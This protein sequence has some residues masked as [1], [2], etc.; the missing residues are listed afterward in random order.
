M[1]QKVLIANRGEIACRI[2][3]T[4]RSLGVR[5]VAV[6]SEADRHARHVRE[7]DEAYCI[8]PAPAALSY[9]NQKE[10][11]RIAREAGA[12]G[13]HPGYGFLSENA[14][15][16]EA[17][18]E[19][20]LAFCGPTGEQM[21][22]FGLKHTARSLAEASGTP[23]LPG[24]GLLK[25][26]TEAVTAAA[27]IGYPV[28]LKSSAGGGGIGMRR[29]ADEAALRESFEAVV[30]LGK[31]NFGEGGVFLEKLITRAR[32]IEV[33][34]FG[35]GKGQVWSLGER[36]CS[37]QRRNQKVVEETPAPGLTEEVREELHRTARDLAASIHYRSAGTVEFLYDV[38]EARF[39]FLEMNTRLQ[40]EHPVTEEVWGVDLVEAMVRLAAGES[41]KALFADREAC[42]AA[43]EVR[44]YAEDPARDFRPDCGL[45]TAWEVP[46]GIRC[47]G[48]IEAGTEVSPHY[49]PMLAKLIVWGETRAEALEKLQRGLGAVQL[50]GL[51]TN[52]AYLQE[53]AGQAF[54]AEG[55]MTTGSLGEMPF[56]P[57]QVE[58]LEAG[59]QTTV[60]DFPGRIGYWHVGVPPSGPMDSV[61]LRLGNRSLGNP[62][63]APALEATLQGPKLRFFEKTWV[64]L[65]G[66]RSD[67]FW[68]GQPVPFG[69]PFEVSAGSVLDVGSLSGRGQRMYVAIRGGF[70]LPK[71]LGSASTFILGQFGG[72]GGRVLQ[73]GDVLPWNPVSG[74]F[75]ASPDSLPAGPEFPEVWEIGVLSGPHGA[76][77]FFREEYLQEFLRADWEVHFNSARTGVRLIG[78]KPGWVREDG[79]E[80]GLHPSNIHDNAY[81]V[82]AIDFTGD[83]PVI[84]GPDGPSLGGFVCPFTVASAELWKLGQLRPGDA[85]RFRLWTL[86]QAMEHEMAWEKWIQDSNRSQPVLPAGKS[87]S[88]SEDSPVLR[89]RD[90]EGSVPAVTYR[91]SGD[92]Y[93][94]IEYGPMVLDLALRM[95]VQ[96]LFE[97]LQDEGIE[98]IHEM[99]PGIRSLQIHYDHR[100]VSQEA[101]LA[102]LERI[103]QTIPD[104]ESLRVPTRIVHL[105]LSW[106]DESTQVAIQRYMSSVNPK[107]PWCPDNIEFIRRING[108]ESRE[109]VKEILFS[110]SYLVMGLGDVYLG[111]PVATPLDPRQRLV[112]TKYNP[113]RTWT[114]EN[115]VGIGGA[116]LCVY[117]MEGPGGYQFVGRTVQMWNRY[118][119]TADFRE[120]KPWLLR[121]F[122]QIRFY[123]VSSE[124]LGQMRE[125]FIEGKF[126]LRIEESSF[127]L[128]EYLKFLEDHKE[129][130]AVFRKTQR[131]AFAE[132]RQRWEEA[133]LSLEVE[134]AAVAGDEGGGEVAIPEGC[135]AI[136]SPMPGNVWKLRVTEPGPVKKDEVLVVLESMKMEIPVKAPVE[137]EIVE[138]VTA[139]HQPVKAGEPMFYFR[140]G[141]DIP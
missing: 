102:K 1:L 108:L 49:D 127:V 16:A 15:F 67:A 94:L 40:V 79:G 64:C 80:A 141:K 83:M 137:G 47:D 32:H 114:P 133:G 111:A 117:G 58:V 106:D 38:G 34:V 130:I 73:V 100:L 110:A 8:G 98:G 113:A 4:L 84:L 3:R 71:Y 77:D 107:A 75:S 134:D 101:L 43:M 17:C 91:Q 6:Y 122:D 30:N 86:P 124:E 14:A 7:A 74:D 97:R 93:L 21:R 138:V 63:G 103:E 90:G 61:A 19:A 31:N 56:A 123:P 131:E 69:I 95:R 60:Q 22:Q 119:Q 57:C 59:T 88:V 116:Y 55:K 109:A 11:L 104:P 42:G 125:D 99:T 96:V 36:D 51:A 66:A 26:V 13:L 52:L 121:F 37:L 25:S 118:R 24:T 45:V 35:D 136:D 12:D 54:F 140:P 129:S 27:D 85:V 29:C 18:E 28:M 135:S 126:R 62:E 72:H 33:Q 76:P 128:G 53:I 41:V 2:I 50:G 5:S 81:A 65:T 9:L 92:R 10:I 20:G 46:S 112:T 105:P 39:Y 89:R 82:G 70:A 44:L 23:L 68:E 78:P 48:W 132:E 120:G 139:E 115:A 87:F